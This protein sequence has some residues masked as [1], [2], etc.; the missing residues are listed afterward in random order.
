MKRRL[1]G[2][3]RDRGDHGADGVV[4]GAIEAVETALA[5]LR[6]HRVV[7]RHDRAVI[8]LADQRRIVLAAVGIDQ[9]PRKAGDHRRRA[10]QR[11]KLPRHHLDADVVG[12]VSV[13]LARRQ[14][15]VAIFLGQVAPGVI[16]KEHEAA[17][18]VAFQGFE[19]GKDGRAGHRFITGG[20]GEPVR[21]GLRTGR[22]HNAVV[23]PSFSR[24]SEPGVTMRRAAALNRLDEAGCAR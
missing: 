20:A 5:F 15:E 7:R 8:E 4:I 16:G 3:R 13:E 11:R 24:N 21:S 19:G 10:G 9:E 18:A 6:R 17:A 2:S 22:K 1:A 14:T 23:W 12:D